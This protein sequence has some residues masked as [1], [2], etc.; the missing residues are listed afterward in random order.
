MRLKHLALAVSALLV[1]ASA[2]SAA[3]VTNDL[4]LRN[5]PTTRSAVI[6]TMPAGARVG[7]LGCRGSWCRVEWRGLIG[8]ASASYLA[9]GGGA[10][11]YAPPVYLAPPPVVSFGIQFGSGPRWYRGRDWHRRGGWHGRRG[12]RYGRALRRR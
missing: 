6:D 10:Y 12:G 4:N 3:I 8:Y 9:R 5:R 1:S 2:A 7:V 11:A